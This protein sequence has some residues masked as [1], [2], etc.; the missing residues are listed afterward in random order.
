MR[1]GGI[2]AMIGD[3]DEQQVQGER[4]EEQPFCFAYQ[5]RQ[6]GGQRR[7]AASLPEGRDAAQPYSGSIIVSRRTMLEPRISI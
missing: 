6:A 5:A 4:A 1:P 2:L 3:E 7:R